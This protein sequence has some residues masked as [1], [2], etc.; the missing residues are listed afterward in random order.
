M[1]SISN[2]HMQIFREKAITEEKRDLINIFI[3]V[4]SLNTLWTITYVH[5]RQ[6]WLCQEKT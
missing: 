6:R 5:V 2:W 4:S 1:N 3:P